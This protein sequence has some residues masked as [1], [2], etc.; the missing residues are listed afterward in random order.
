MICSSQTVCRRYFLCGRSLCRVDRLAV[1][2]AR[3]LQVDVDAEPPLQL[4]DR[5]LDVHLPLAREQQL[6][7]L[8]IAA[9][10]DRRI[11]LLE[12]VYRLVDFV[13]VTA[14]LRL[15]GV[16]QH[17]LGI[18]QRGEDRPIGLVSERVVGEGVFQLRHGPEISGT[19]LR[20]VRLRFA[21]QQ[22]DVPS[23]SGV[24]RVFCARSSPFS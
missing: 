8:R 22:H 2:H 19:Q 23:R 3:R 10:A 18:L 14:A 12:A 4:R 15:D 20:H 9:V 5:H 21:L 17:R 24:S 16:R 6:F 7:R 11:F 13:F 1:R